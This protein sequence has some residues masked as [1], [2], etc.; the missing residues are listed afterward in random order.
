MKKKKQSLQLTG[1]VT[2][3]P[4]SLAI[5]SLDDQPEGFDRASTALLALEIIF[6]ATRQS[7][8]V[9]E[10]PKKREG[11]TMSACRPQATRGAYSRTRPLY[12]LRISS[13]VCSLT[14]LVSSNGSTAFEKGTSLS[15]EFISSLERGEVGMPAGHA[16]L[17]K[18][19]RAS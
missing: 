2:L 18:R 16:I 10:Q 14:I 13:N 12:D 19:D 17:S 8:S 9:S 15:E 3:E 7:L 1:L 5:R 6:E 11:E 4:C